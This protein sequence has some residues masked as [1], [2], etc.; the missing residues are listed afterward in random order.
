MRSVLRLALVVVVAALGLTGTVVAITPHAAS[1]THAVSLAMGDL[2]DL[3]PLAQ[4]SKM[5]DAAGNLIDELFVEN[6]QPFKLADVPAPVIDAVLAVEDAGFYEHRGVN[7]KGLLRAGLANVSAGGTTQGGSTI[8]Q[9]LVKNALVGSKRDANRKILEAAYSVELEKRL[10]KDQILEAYLNRIYLGNNAYGLQ[11]AARTYFGKDVSQLD[12][13]EGA[14]LAGMIRNPVGYDPIYRAERS[15]TRFKEA[16]ARLVKVGKL[17]ADRAAALGTTWPLPDRLQNPTKVPTA[18]TYFSAEVRKVLLNSSTILGPDYQQRYNALF[19]GGLKIITTFDPKAQQAAIAARDAQLPDTNGRFQAAIVSLENATGA[20]RAMVGGP[21]F[22]TTQVNLATTPRQTGSA[23][24]GFILAAGIAAGLQPDDQINGINDRT[25]EFWHTPPAQDDPFTQD[26]DETHDGA[27]RLD[28]MT[29]N[30][31]NCAFIR[32][33]FSVGGARVVATAHRMGVKGNLQNI[34][35][36]ATGG[37]EVSAL[38]MAAGYST[39]ANEGVQRDPFYVERI[40][41]SQGR[42]IYQHQVVD[43]VALERGAALRTVD[44]L[45]GVVRQGTA[46]RAKLDDGR[47]QAGK[48]GTY[49]AD[50]H[51]WFVGFTKQYTTSVYLGNPN[52]P[53]PMQRIPEFLKPPEGMQAFS[54]VVGGSYPAL[55]WKDY[56][57]TMSEGLEPLDW[58]APPAL[59]RKPARVYAPGQDCFGVVVG[60]DD[61]GRSLIPGKTPVTAAIDPDDAAAPAAVAAVGQQFYNC[62]Y[63]GFVISGPKPTTTIAGDGTEPDAPG[64][65]PGG[66]VPPT[67]TT[68]P[69]TTPTTRKP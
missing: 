7:A 54:N 6:V 59:A 15:R 42:V 32:M 31:V 40:E 41:D 12:Q 68:K 33:Y 29:W 17:D 38:D 23:I 21:G 24:K 67:T 35:A 18:R 5:Y 14:F 1:Y 49:E 51:A 11:A 16:L 25:C 20:V 8:T 43:N 10:T 26:A 9:Q 63:G 50:K 36:F 61:T 3:A 62:H 66:T 53:E 44:I 52:T 28:Q 69:R 55:I 58:E 19:R 34:F 27:G 22:D 39:L 60:D 4:G 2:P 13:V 64:A 30:S 45:K 47:P 65:P 56:T 57:Q 37:N 46:T 48:T